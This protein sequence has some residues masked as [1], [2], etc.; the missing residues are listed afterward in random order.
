MSHKYLR[1]SHLLAALLLGLAACAKT[2]PALRD[3]QLSQKV[4]DRFGQ[5]ATVF[6]S[7]EVVTVAASLFNP[8][9]QTLRVQYGG[10]QLV[11]TQIL[12]ASGNSVNSDP[13][14]ATVCTADIKTVTFAAKETLNFRYDWDQKNAGGNPVA[15]G[16]YDLET[17][18][19]YSV[20]GNLL[21]KSPKLKTRIEIR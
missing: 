3:L 1:A 15:A 20:D 10:C 4:Q 2:D 5:A 21:N 17:T 8:N 9:S 16:F 13:S 14:P 18:A 11:M 12:D 19:I 7:G 6:N